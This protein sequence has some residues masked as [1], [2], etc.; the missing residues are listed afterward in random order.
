MN[1]RNN[2]RVQSLIKQSI[3]TNILIQPKKKHHLQHRS[4]SF[5]VP[6]IKIKK[7]SIN[8]CN[9]ILIQK[10]ETELKVKFNYH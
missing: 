4:W 5:E 10:I 2:S 6:E 1:N 9:Q 3:R 7:N 8:K